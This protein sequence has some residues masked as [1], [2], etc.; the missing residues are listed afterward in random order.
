MS[1]FFQQLD[2]SVLTDALR[3]IIPAILCIPLHELSHGFVAL[4]LGDR[5]AKNAGRLTMNPLKHV[6]IFGLICMAVF[7]FGWAK[8]VPVDMRNFRNPK[9][10]MALTALAGPV[11]NVLFCLVLLFLFG[12][13]APFLSSGSVGTFFLDLISTTAVL[14]L[15]LAVFNVIPVPPLDG[16]KVLFSLLGDRAYRFILR[17]ERYGMILLVVLLTSGVLS[18]PMNRAVSFLLDRFT[19]LIETGYR[20]GFLLKY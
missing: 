20:L 10:G 15:S 1:G 5:T 7:R 3:N 2:T 19:F 12:F 17:Y 11:S 8:P 4:K 9:R 14:S 16:S 13:L 18:G 6:D